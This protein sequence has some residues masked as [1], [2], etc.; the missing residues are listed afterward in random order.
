MYHQD[1][2]KCG[3]RSAHSDLM[4][5]RQKISYDYREYRR[6]VM[7]FRLL[8]VVIALAIFLPSPTTAQQR[9]CTDPFA[10]V[11]IEFDSSIPQ[12]DTAYL[13][14]SW[15]TVWIPDS[16]CILAASMAGL[17]LYDIDSPE[18]SVLLVPAPERVFGHIAIN[19]EDL[20]I[21]FS[22]SEN[23]LVYLV[24]TTG[25]VDTFQISG[26]IVTDIAFSSD[27]RLLGVASSDIID[28]MGFPWYARIQLWDLATHEK[29]AYFTSSTG[30][31]QGIAFA[32]NSPHFLT[33]GVRPGYQGN[34]IEYW[35]IN[36]LS[37]LWV[38]RELRDTQWTSIDPLM[39]LRTATHDA[40]FAVWG[41][42]QYMNDY[43]YTGGAIQ[44]WNAEERKRQ[45]EFMVNSRDDLN[46]GHYVTALAFNSDGSVLAAN[47]EDGPIKLWNTA[48]GSEIAAIDVSLANIREIT[49]SP[50]N[51][52]LAIHTQDEILVWDI[53]H[54]IAYH[55]FD[56]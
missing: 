21:A 55:T 17:S 42:S 7:R 40:V 22:V 49:F 2:K 53:E 18:D 13:W 27:G 12:T 31:I 3:W 24:S 43:N 4:A 26:E 45:L 25:K 56:E 6:L 41:L 8:A 47:I 15:D 48:D 28:D 29:I 36:T 51:R 33:N 37:R 54:M 44:L 1:Y 46:A 38:Y 32:P 20:S 11:S 14:T 9:S 30:A 5:F 10:P 34:D 16:H 39:P 19:P 50:D 23:P 35:D 52:F